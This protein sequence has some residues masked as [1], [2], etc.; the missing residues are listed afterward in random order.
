V[1]GFDSGSYALEGSAE[2]KSFY[3]VLGEQQHGYG[4]SWASVQAGYWTG[5]GFQDVSGRVKVLT[6]PATIGCEWSANAALECNASIGTSGLSRSC[7]FGQLNFSCAGKE[8]TDNVDQSWSESISSVG[9]EV[10]FNYDD[11]NNN[12]ASIGGRRVRG[13][14]FVR[15]QNEVQSTGFGYFTNAYGSHAD[16]S[17]TA[18][19]DVKID[20]LSVVNDADDASETICSTKEGELSAI[21]I[22]C[23]EPL[24][25]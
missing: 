21:H 6:E 16:A 12:V 3:S 13:Y 17:T 5:G 24:T 23:G 1:T 25:N 14:T 18:D 20:H 10:L 11:T 7:S 19:L 22:A 15:A 9:S 8:G 2:A 4:H